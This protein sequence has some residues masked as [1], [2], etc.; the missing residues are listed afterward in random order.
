ME[1][2]E[3][4][5]KEKSSNTFKYN[6][7]LWGVIVVALFAIIVILLCEGNQKHEKMLDDWGKD[8]SE[9]RT[10]TQEIE[11]PKDI[12]DDEPKIQ[13]NDA[14]TEEKKQEKPTVSAKTEETD[15][16]DQEDLGDGDD[17]MQVEEPTEQIGETISQESTQSSETQTNNSSEGITTEE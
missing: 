1:N 17:F 2:K 6:K 7:G 14:T 15:F 11:K 13:A 3:T 5:K 12:P 16:E 10:A 4:S 9:Q 8:K